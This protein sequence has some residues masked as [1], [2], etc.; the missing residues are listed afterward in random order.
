MGVIYNF[1]IFLGGFYGCLCGGEA[2]K[3]V[4]GR[5]GERERVGLKSRSCCESFDFDERGVIHG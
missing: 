4:G 3:G 2:G 5:R 1:P